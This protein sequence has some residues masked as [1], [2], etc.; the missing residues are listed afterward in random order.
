MVHNRNT[1]VFMPDEI[2]YLLSELLNKFGNS[3]GNIIH[4]ALHFGVIFVWNDIQYRDKSFAHEEPRCFVVRFKKM[5]ADKKPSVN[6]A[7]YGVMSVTFS[8]H[9]NSCAEF[10]HF[11]TQND[12]LGSGLTD[13]RAVVEA[14]PHLEAS[15]V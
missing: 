12:A 9:R 2:I 1:I 14:V 4:F 8:L 3:I 10:V 7:R 15:D 13:C 11:V 6:A 5:G